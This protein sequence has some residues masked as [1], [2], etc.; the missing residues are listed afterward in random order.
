VL[1]AQLYKDCLRL[2]YHVATEVCGCVCRS[3]R[4][5]SFVRPAC[6]LPG[7]GL[8]CVVTDVS[9]SRA[10]VQHKTVDPQ[11]VRRLVKQQFFLHAHETDANKIAVLK[12]N[13]MSAL[14]NYVMHIS[15]GYVARGALSR[16]RRPNAL[17]TTFFVC[18]CFGACTHFH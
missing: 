2:V 9:L 12:K 13:A 10:G 16:P 17:P 15:V 18:S 5:W 11:Q 3:A 4:P 7:R 8:A 6:F 14:T 1:L